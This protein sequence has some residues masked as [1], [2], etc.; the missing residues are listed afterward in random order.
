[1]TL[2]RRNFI[3]NGCKGCVAAGIGLSWLSMASC[4]VTKVVKAEPQNSTLSID[5]QLFAENKSI[6]LRTMQ[7]EHDILVQKRNTIYTAIYLQCSHR[8]NPVYANPSGIVC[9]LHGSQFD[10]NGNVKVGP[11]TESL[12]QFSLKEEGNRLLIDIS[13]ELNLR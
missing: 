4:S 3:K 6:L 7:L 2:D 1:M 12:K 10:L 5:I 8:N 11:A 13:K 9:N